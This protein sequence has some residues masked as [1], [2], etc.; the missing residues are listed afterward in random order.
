MTYLKPRGHEWLQ[1]RERSEES[2][3]G[4]GEGVVT[5]GCPVYRKREV[6]DLTECA[7]PGRGQW[8]GAGLVEGVT[9]RV[10]VVGWWW[11]MVTGLPLL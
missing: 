1:G 11:G 2:E 5:S 4:G 8:F 9:D 3:V 10:R 6:S 7:K